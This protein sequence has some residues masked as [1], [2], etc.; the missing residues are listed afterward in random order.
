MEDMT[1]TQQ[2]AKQAFREGRWAEAER[3]YR[4]LLEEHPR[5]ATL[6]NDLGT[7]LQT[8]ERHRE[9]CDCFRQAVKCDPELGVA[10]L[11]LAGVLSVLH[12]F[13]ESLPHFEQSIRLMPEKSE[14]HYYQGHAFQSMGNRREALSA[15][16]RA[17]ALAP[18]EKD[19]L[20]SLGRLYFDLRDYPRAVDCFRKMTELY[21]DDASAWLTLGYLHEKDGSFQQA[22]DCYRRVLRL[23]QD[24]PVARHRLA[25]ILCR[26]GHHR[27]SIPEFEAALRFAPGRPDILVGYSKAL[28]ATGQYKK[29]WEAFEYRKLGTHGTWQL[30]QLPVW[31]G[32][33]DKDQ[34]ILAYGEE[35]SGTEVLFASCVPDLQEDIGHCILECDKRLH[36]LFARSFPEVTLVLPAVEPVTPDTFLGKNCDAQIALGSLP[37]YYR[38]AH[39]AFPKQ[40]AYLKADSRKQ[41]LW[42]ARLSE[43]GK[44][45]RVGFSWEGRGTGEPVSQQRMELPLWRPLVQGTSCRWFNLQLGRIGEEADRLQEPW[46]ASIFR[47]PEVL[48][49]QD[50][51]ELAAMIASLD[52]VICTSGLMAHLAGALGIPVWLLLHTSCDWRW[53][54]LED[55]SP[56]HPTMRIFRHREEVPSERFFSELRETFEEFLRHRA[57]SAVKSPPPLRIIQRTA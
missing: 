16:C 38:Y 31:Q 33:P 36:P 23:E 24:S 20:L 54:L 26:F 25:E 50:F 7:L 40:A 51:E 22:M 29:G 53:N 42:D 17:T 9:A 15:F 49:S 32:H 28:L 14:P 52:L 45:A 19:C 56:W 12:R 35:G 48:Q 11:N 27:E 2:E 6:W 3:H 57:E 30:H 47:Y 13:E 37:R 21:P 4:N 46:Q 10:H 44:S 8:Q 1:R 41:A 34:T 5:E 43:H 39:D 55:R 18:E